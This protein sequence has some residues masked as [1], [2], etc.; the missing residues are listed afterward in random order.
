MSWWTWNVKTAVLVRKTR[1]RV[2]NVSAGGCQIETA[3][4]LEVGTVGLLEVEG[5]RGRQ[6]ETIRVTHTTIRPGH[7]YPGLLG[8]EF[9][10]LEPASPQS[11]RREIAEIEALKRT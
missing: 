2:L 6:V 10:V 9:L 8:V 11:F 4:R 1:A 7:S 5:E 3:G